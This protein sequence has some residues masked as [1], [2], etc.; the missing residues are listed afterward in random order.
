MLNKTLIAKISIKNISKSLNWLL[1]G[2]KPYIRIDPIDIDEEI[3][4]NIFKLYKSVY[5]KFND[6]FFINNKNALLKYNRWVIITNDKN[7][8]SGFALFTENQFGLKLGI[9]AA[10]DLAKSKKALI[11]FIIKSLNIEGIYAE[12]SG[13]LEDVIL[14]DVPKLKAD[15]AMKILALEKRLNKI[16]NDKYHYKRNIGNQ[17]KIMVGKPLID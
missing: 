11:Q 7:E 15:E 8:L 12:V 10:N 6:I 13:R 4:D 16:D 2:K 1:Q 17:M 14:N 3:K 9:A 5:S